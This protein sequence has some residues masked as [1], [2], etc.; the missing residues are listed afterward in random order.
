MKGSAASKDRASR[1]GGP[2]VA[3]G[4]V[5][6]VAVAVAGFVGWKLQ[7]GSAGSTPAPTWVPSPEEDRWP[8]L[9]RALF[10]VRQS[11]KNAELAVEAGGI[12]GE[13]RQYR[14]ALGLFERAETLNPNLLAAVTGQGQMWM[15]L[16]RPGKAAKCFERALRMA[17]GTAPLLLVLSRSYASLRDFPEAL[18]LGHEAEKVAPSDPEVYRTLSLVYGELV[19]TDESLKH[20]A[21]ACELSP[22]DPDNWVL[23]ASQLLRG[24]RYQEAEKALKRALDL[25][26]ALVP[27][28]LYY[29]QALIDGRKTTAADREAFGHLARVR[30]VEPN[31]SQALAM[32]GGILSRAGNTRLAVSVLR[33]AREA[34]PTDSQ[35]LIAL[36]QALIKNRQGEEGV[37]L[38]TKGQQLGPKGVGFLDLEELVRKNPDPKLVLRLVDLYERQQMTDQ[39][40]HVLESAL[41]RKP[42]DA[43]LASRL[44]SLRARAA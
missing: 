11:P 15:A 34:A 18:R 19:M 40:I 17:P 1:H 43:M 39:A 37:R 22:K 26:V 38:V 4:V 13:M 41:K 33:Q 16:G 32:M 44:A 20:A 3:L 9:S 28:N 42:G 5:L 24:Q 29:A 30:L 35:I 36:G 23:Q 27:A 25:D 10:A 6:V 14:Q 7:P 8:E 31:N 21:R 12:A 2:A